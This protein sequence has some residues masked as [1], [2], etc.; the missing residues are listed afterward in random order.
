MDF[1]RIKRDT[2]GIALLVSPSNDY[3]TL[4]GE[5]PLRGTHCNACKMEAVFKEFGY[6]VYRRENI[7][8][9]DF[10]CKCITTVTY[11]QVCKRILIYFSGHG[12]DGVTLKMEDILVDNILEWFKPPPPPVS[13]ANR[14]YTLSENMVKMFFF[15]VCQGTK[16]DHGYISKGNIR[17]V[18]ENAPTSVKNGKYHMMVILLLLLLLLLLLKL[19]KPM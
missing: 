16:R 4:D 2:I 7:H 9:E 15:D 19:A 14:D 8:S 1:N 6:V 5:W 18:A 11:P 12:S 13:A 3:R 10:S 17:N